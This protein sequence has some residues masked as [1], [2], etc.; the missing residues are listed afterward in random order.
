MDVPGRDL[1]SGIRA[2][3]NIGGVLFAS[4][5]LSREWA[6]VALLVYCSLLCV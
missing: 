6:C 2:T 5:S 4:F 3:K 1:G